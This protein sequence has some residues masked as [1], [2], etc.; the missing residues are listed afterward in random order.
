M[1]Y[2]HALSYNLAFMLLFFLSSLPLK[3]QERVVYTGVVVDE[4]NQPLPNV[5][6]QIE[7]SAGGT[8]TDSVGLFSIEATPNSRLLF[9][10][11]GFA[12]HR[13]TLGEVRT[14]QI[15]M[16]REGMDLEEVVVIGYG[17]VRKN[18]LTGSVSRIGQEVMETR[19]ATSVTDYLKGSVAGVNIGINNTASGGGSIEVRGPASL[20]ASSSPL[21]VLDGTIYYGTM[22]DINPNDIES[23]DVLKDASSTAIY[24]SKGSAGVIMIT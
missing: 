4:S 9:S 12:A 17:T 1:Y 18:D 19:V 13:E 5:S 8:S 11:V 15:Q 6:V 3:G 20:Q 14:L 2:R 23:I 7:Q 16:Q 22:S 24:G 21:I 10:I